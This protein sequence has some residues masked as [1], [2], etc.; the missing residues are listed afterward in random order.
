VKTEYEQRWREV[1]QEVLLE[2]GKWREEHPTATL[3][4]IEEEVDRRMARLRAGLVE[5]VAMSSAAAEVGKRAGE[6]L[7]TCPTC[8]T[9]LYSRGKQ[10]R[11]LT[12]TGEQTVRLERSYGYCPTCQVGFFP[13]G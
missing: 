3:Q 2:M 13:P 1:A 11:K 7:L 10:V 12:T 9:V 5:G 4:E 8:G 6:T